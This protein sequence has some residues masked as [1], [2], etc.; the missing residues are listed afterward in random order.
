MTAAHIDAIADRV[1]A[2]RVARDDGRR[3]VIVGIDG[4]AGSGKTTLAAAASAALGDCPVVHMDD[5]YPGWDGL[6][7][8]IPILVAD[9]LEPI[10]A[11]RP[12]RFRRW[13]W[14]A[15]APGQWSVIEPPATLLIEGVGSCARP[16]VPFIDVPVWIDTT[17]EVRKRRALDRDGAMFADHWDR[18][19]QQEDRLLTDDPI[20]ERA[21]IVI[22]GDPPTNA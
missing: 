6:A 5:I 22:H 15:D 11:G 13:D 16:T 18:W 19:K 3:T 14:A 4:R 10:A 8:S 20:R 17:A 12:A 21:A 9:V 2:V 7:A 1:R